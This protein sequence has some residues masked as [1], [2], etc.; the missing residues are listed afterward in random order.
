MFYH[1]VFLALWALLLSLW[2]KRH[3]PFVSELALLVL[4]P[5]GSAL[6]TGVLDFLTVEEEK[7]KFKTQLREF[8]RERLDTRLLVIV[9]VIFA[10]MVL[11]NTSVTIIPV[12]DGKTRKATLVKLESNTR[13]HSGKLKPQKTAQLPIYF[14]NPF[15]V[16]YVLKLEGYLDK[17][18]T[19]PPVTGAVIVPEQDLQPLPTVLFRPMTVEATT[20]GNGGSTHWFTKD[21]DGSYQ[22]ETSASGQTSWLTGIKRKQPTD[23]QF[24]WS[25]QTQAMGLNDAIEANMLLLWRQPKQLKSNS[26]DTVVQFRPEQMV[27]A[28]IANQDGG[29]FISGIVVNIT[30]ETYQDVEVGYYEM[31]GLK[32]EMGNISADGDAICRELEKRTR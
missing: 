7:T 16:N 23:M 25:L 17:V 29:K 32:D 9:Y 31:G 3:I 19:V 28:L 10:T 11:L 24:Q 30:T 18:I 6:F 12:Q 20:L 5:L 22:Y 26:A 2:V 21:V 15:A 1:V 13:V 8:I 14:A 4:L 27:C